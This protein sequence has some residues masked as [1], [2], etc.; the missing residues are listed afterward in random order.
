[1]LT[2]QHFFPLIDNFLGEVK[3]AYFKQRI[4]RNA[5]ENNSY[6]FLILSII[7]IRAVVRFIVRIILRRNSNTAKRQLIYAAGM[8]VN[9]W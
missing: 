1:L 7:G 5:P 3:T 8:L 6:V 9:K 2:S 4:I